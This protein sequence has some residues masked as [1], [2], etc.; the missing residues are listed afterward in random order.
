MAG[1]GIYFSALG[2]GIL[3]FWSGFKGWGV[4]STLQDVISGKHPSG[5]ALNAP[6][7]VAAGSGGQVN[8]LAAAAGAGALA[9]ASGIAGDAMQYQGHAYSYGGAPGRNGTSPWDC[10]SFCNWVISH[11]LNLPWP[12][13]GQYDGTSHGP[14]TG[15]WGAWFTGR[16][17]TVKGGI[18]S[19]QAGDV[20]VWAGH[21]GI[22]IG[23]GQMVSAL[24][25]ADGTKVTPIA[26][27]GNGPLLA[28]GRY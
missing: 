5:A 6:A 22:A 12:G 10:S 15:V 16:R 7:D 4:V 26:G 13:P 14:P 21:M 9:G 28:V 2:A 11:D 1:R 25:H 3:L 19:A 17:M 8:P 23:G 18:A 27:Y 24:D 20:I